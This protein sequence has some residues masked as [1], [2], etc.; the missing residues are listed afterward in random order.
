MAT[1]DN[2]PLGIDVS[3]HQ[4]DIDWAGV[5]ASGVRFAFIKATEGTHYH[6][7]FFPQN[8][9]GANQFGIFRGA[10]HYARPRLNSGRGE[11]EYCFDYVTRGELVRGDM[12]AL[13]MEET[14]NE[15][16]GYLGDWVAEWFSRMEELSGAKPLLYSSP[17]YMAPHGLNESRLTNNGLWL[18][19]WGLS[20]V[21]TPPAPWPHVAFWQYSASGR[22][23]GI[24]GDVDLDVF[25][26]D[27]ERIPLYGVP[28]QGGGEPPVDPPTNPD[29]QALLAILN[30]SQALVDLIRT[31]VERL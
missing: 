10:Y 7:P 23:G 28:E 2:L 31:L 4:E 6:D 5:A 19:S 22:I 20:T 1:P 26:G 18:A 21:P 17:G 29:K 24:N 15:G 8:W 3:N 27:V 14:G 12:F 13:D 9:I 25:N 30:Q 16:A 11:A